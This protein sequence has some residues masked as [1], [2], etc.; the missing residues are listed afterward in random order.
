VDTRLVGPGD[1]SGDYQ[2]W[3][4]RVAAE[5]FDTVGPILIETPDKRIQEAGGSSPN[6]KPAY[7]K[8]TDLW[9]PQTSMDTAVRGKYY[10]SF[11]WNSTRALDNRS[12]QFP[13]GGGGRNE[14]DAGDLRAIQDEM[15]LQVEL[16][17]LLAE[18]H[19]RSTPP[20]L[21][22]AAELI[23]RSRTVNGE[24][25]PVTTT[26]VPAGTGCVPRR[27]DGTCGDLF[28]ALVYEKR[29][30]TYGTG[31]AFFDARGW[32]CLLE[33]TPMHLA[34][35]GTQLDIMGKVI[36]SYGGRTGATAGAPKPTNCPLLH[37]P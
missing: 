11:Y 37:R 27:Y 31:I 26:G 21:V 6:F 15:L 8:T 29:L 28:D 35:P 13:A 22:A 16:D 18:A 30:E 7:F 33:G 36:Y 5:R 4:Q 32:G 2:I 23:N 12:S 17:L 25:P 20:D 34:P 10:V 14:N 24:L 9:P 3:L 1:T 19:L